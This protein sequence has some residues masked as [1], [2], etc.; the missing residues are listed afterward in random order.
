MINMTQRLF[1]YG[2]LGPGRPNE[3]VLS[4][5]GGTWEEASVRG[6]LKSEGWGADMGYPGIVLDENGDE[7]KGYIFCSDNLDK[8]WGE[9]DEFEGG[10]Y[11]RVLTAVNTKDK[12][13]ILAYIYILKEI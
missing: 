4:E 8:H 5:I 1:V 9:L 3:H 13:E 2:T 6:Y 7:V 10:E 11:R 12:K